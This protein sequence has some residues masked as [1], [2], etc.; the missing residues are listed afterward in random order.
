MLPSVEVHNAF[1]RSDLEVEAGDRLWVFEIKC[2]CESKEVDGLL[3]EAVEQMGS[4]H[5]GS[6]RSGKKVIRMALVFDVSERG[7]SAWKCL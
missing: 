4:R 3:R 7:F 6:K 5:Y 2:A 1:G